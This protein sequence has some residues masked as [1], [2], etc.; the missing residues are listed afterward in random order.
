MPLRALM[1]SSRATTIPVRVPGN[2]NFD[3]LMQRITLSVQTNSAAVKM[4]LGNGMP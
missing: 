4:M 2:P 1:I 3:R